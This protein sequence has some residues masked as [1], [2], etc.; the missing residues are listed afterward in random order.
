[1]TTADRATITCIADFPNTS[2]WK[3]LPCARMGQ[4][5]WAP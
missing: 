3:T 2:F 1:M 5:S 4:S